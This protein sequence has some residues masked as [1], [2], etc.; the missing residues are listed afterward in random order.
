MSQVEE[1]A[2]PLIVHFSEDLLFPN[3]STPGLRRDPNGVKHIEARNQA[4]VASY[5]KSTLKHFEGCL[6]QIS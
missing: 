1:K 6:A 2:K 5:L 4:R 3:T